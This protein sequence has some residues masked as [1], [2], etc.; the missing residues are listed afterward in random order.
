MT[1]AGA[2]F[3]AGGAATCIA[4]FTPQLFPVWRAGFVAGLPVIKAHPCA[5]S[6]VTFLFALGAVLNFLGYAESSDRLRGPGTALIG[7]TTVLWLISLA[8]RWTVIP[9]VAR[10][11]TV[12]T[13]FEPLAA[14]AG[15]LWLIAAACGLGALGVLAFVVLS[16]HLVA[17]WVGWTVAAATAAMAAQLVIT[18]DLP[19]IELYLPLLLVGIA[20]R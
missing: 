6:A 14:W 10:L 1:L 20:L 9:K 7:I 19:P 18:R 4:A 11:E 5:W 13:W 3:T 16:T 8:F 15:G 17:A 2:L 12:P